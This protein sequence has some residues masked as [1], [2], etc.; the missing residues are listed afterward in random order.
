[1]DQKKFKKLA[2][3]VKLDI[4]MNRIDQGALTDRSIY[5]KP[6]SKIKPNLRHFEAIID[7]AESD[8]FKALLSPNPRD[9]YV[10]NGSEGPYYPETFFSNLNGDQRKIMSRCASM[11]TSNPNTTQ[12]AIVQGPPGTGKSTTITAMILQILFRARKMFPGANQ[13]FTP[14]ILITAPS[15]A[16][17][18]E[19]VRR[20]IDLNQHLKNED[21]FNLMRVGQL[22]TIAKDVQSVSF[23]ELRDQKLKELRQKTSNKRSLEMEIDNIQS[24]INRLGDKLAK[25]PSS[26]RDQRLKELKQR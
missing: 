23:D 6:V 16:A 3:F 25:C 24:K 19:L 17:V 11:A 22:R 26:D 18:D 2:F 12:V 1:M 13:F 7:S 5:I 9:F 21:K 15:N 4:S 10:R 8:L 14:R 20:L